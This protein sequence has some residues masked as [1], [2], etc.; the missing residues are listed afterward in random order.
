M[1][2]VLPLAVEGAGHRAGKKAALPGPKSEVSEDS[3]RAG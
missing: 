3:E 1:N 2:P